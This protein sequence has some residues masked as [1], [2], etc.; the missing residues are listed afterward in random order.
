MSEKLTIAN[1]RN[2]L[3]QRRKTS[4]SG[5]R[6]VSGGD[7]LKPVSRELA[8]NRTDQTPSLFESTPA[9]LPL[10]A[11]LACALT[12]LSECERSVIFGISD[13]VSEICKENCIS[14]YE[15]RKRTDP[16]HHADVAAQDVYAWIRRAFSIPTF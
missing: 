12:G 8:L 10:T 7:G 3:E 16:V 4:T 13:V 14:L 2:A 5:I 6:S 15:P 9:P 11:Y 1:A